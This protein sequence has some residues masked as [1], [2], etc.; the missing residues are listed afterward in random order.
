MGEIH[1]QDQV[2]VRTLVISADSGVARINYMPLPLYVV[3]LQ[4]FRLKFPRVFSTVC[5]L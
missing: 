1:D 5:S 3:R 4:K 2:R